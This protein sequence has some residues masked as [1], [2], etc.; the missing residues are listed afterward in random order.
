MRHVLEELMG[1]GRM[2][3]M[4]MALLLDAICIELHHFFLKAQVT[5]EH[6]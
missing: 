6:I 5:V 1:P 4:A 3:V 2:H